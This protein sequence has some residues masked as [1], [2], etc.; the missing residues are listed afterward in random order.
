M[1]ATSN[2]DSDS[3]VDMNFNAKDAKYFMA[4]SAHKSS[5]SSESSS[6]WDEN[7]EEHSD[8]A[9]IIISN[10]NSRFTKDKTVV[11]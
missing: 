7:T 4:R 3:D 10:K 8:L 9:S 1:D 11:Q 5:S 6:S 2:S